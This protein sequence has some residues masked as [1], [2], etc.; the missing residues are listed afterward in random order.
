[1]AV[2][3]AAPDFRLRCKTLG[4]ARVVGNLAAHYCRVSTWPRSRKSGPPTA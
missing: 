2:S 1:M 3:L 4:L